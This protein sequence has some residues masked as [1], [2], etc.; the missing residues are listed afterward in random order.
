LTT[1]EAQEDYLKYALGIDT[2]L[3][4]I[5]WSFQ[6]QQEYIPHYVTETIQDQVSTLLGVFGRRELSYGNTIAET[7]VLYF[8]NEQGWLIR[9]KVTWKLT[10]ALRLSLGADLFRGTIGG[11]LP[12]EFNFAGFFVNHDRIYTELAY[13]F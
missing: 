8:I 9:P 11:P 6:V 5:D 7:L 3:W 13:N 2:R 4:K 12:G 10:D 1:G